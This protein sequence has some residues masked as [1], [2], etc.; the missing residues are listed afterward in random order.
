MQ[1]KVNG[2]IKSVTDGLKL[3]DLAEQLG[4]DRRKVA[5]E[6]NGQIIPRST[7]EQAALSEG[8]AIE[9]VEFIGGG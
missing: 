9:I 3:A 7:H 4:L 8:D 2:E 1:I 5:I 6:L